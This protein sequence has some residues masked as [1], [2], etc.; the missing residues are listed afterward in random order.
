MP[1]RAR[2]IV[3]HAISANVIRAFATR[4]LSL[5]KVT[6]HECAVWQAFLAS[7]SSPITEPG[8]LEQPMSMSWPISKLLVVLVLVTP[9]A[10]QSPADSLL[11]LLSASWSWYS[12]WGG[13]GGETRTPA[14][15]GY[16]MSLV[17]A[18]A[19]VT[20]TLSYWSH[21][22]DSLVDSGISVILLDT[23]NEYYG[24][25]T[26]SASV[27]GLGPAPYSGSVTHLTIFPD[28]SI[29][30]WVAGLSDG[31]F[32]T[33][34]RAPTS[35]RSSPG[36]LRAQRPIIRHAACVDLAGRVVPLV[37]HARAQAPRALT[38]ASTGSGEAVRIVT[39]R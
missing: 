13:W 39:S 15:E 16:S 12:T 2:T 14:T 22:S 25:P 32:H 20:H 37:H 35:L 27:T 19:P 31:Y 3:E 9:I 1:R 10:A 11:S 30:M 4:T 18:I 5:E 38:V 33:Y 24:H 23:I 36:A 6:K 7:V 8:C 26:W 29:V 28:T 34:H 21:K 17:L